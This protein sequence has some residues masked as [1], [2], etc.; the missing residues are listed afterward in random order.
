MLSSPDEFGWYFFKKKKSQEVSVV[1]VNEDGEAKKFDQDGDV[2]FLDDLL[3]Y[4]EKLES[5]L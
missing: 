4:W 3:G 2:E 1:Y 5:D